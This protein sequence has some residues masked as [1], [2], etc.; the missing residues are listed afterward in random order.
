MKYGACDSGVGA[1][2]GYIMGLDVDMSI[3]S[4]IW[5]M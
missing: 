2:G 4:S 3:C 5:N 1:A